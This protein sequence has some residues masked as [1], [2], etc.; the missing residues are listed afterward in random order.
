MIGQTSLHRRR[1]AQ[2][3][4]H[5]AIVVV[6]V[7]ESDSVTVVL[8]FL[9]ESV[10]EP[11]K[12]ARRHSQGQVLPFDVTGADVIRVG[13]PK[14]RLHLAADALAWR[15]APLFFAG[16][17]AVNLL[18]L[19]I[20]HFYPESALNSFEVRLVRVRGHLNPASDAAGAIFHELHG[21]TRIPA[22]D[23]VGNDQLGIGVNSD[24]R[25]DISPSVILLLRR[26]IF[27]FAA[28]KR[29]NFIALQPFHAKIADM[30]IMERGA[31]RSHVRQQLHNRILSRSRHPACCSN[32][33]AFDKAPD[34]LR[35]GL[36][37]QAVHIDYYAKAALGCQEKSL[38]ENL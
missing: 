22:T 4:M 26:G 19:R 6:H 11:G 8:G 1:H 28:N 36:G 10:C 7:M 9:A 35:S 5:T 17:Y 16:R 25:P 13:I 21:P 30:E 29:P 31:S 34:D 20:V 27:L 38:D 12:P 2:G 3:L 24:P 32:G 15:I 14:D 33:A 23:K 18:E 37:V